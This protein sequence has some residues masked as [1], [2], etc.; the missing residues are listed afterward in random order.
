ML[1]YILKRL[2]LII[3][4]VIG[5]TL[6]IYLLLDL[7]PGDPT[8]LILGTDATTEQIAE[9]RS[10]LG[11]DN[12]VFVRYFNYMSSAVKGDLGSSWY[13]SRPVIDEFMERLPNTLALAFSALA[14]TIVFGL[15]FGTLAAVFQNRPIDGV[16]LVL[17]LLFASMPS[18]WFGLML[19]LI[20]CLELQW[21]PAMGVGTIRHMILPATTLALGTIASQVRMTRSSILDVINMNYVRTA[22][23]KGAGEFRV[24]FHHVIRNALM[25]VVTNWGSYLCNGLRRHDHFRDGLL[26]PRY[27]VVSHK[28]R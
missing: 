18:F 8:T 21:L 9:L 27:L 7:A 4:V 26:H 25:P 28:R 1:K 5:I 10:E 12:N 2:L 23:A 20:F 15:T 17:A 13:N 24:V 3:P 19:Q 11:L 22:R 14:I 6:F 16:T